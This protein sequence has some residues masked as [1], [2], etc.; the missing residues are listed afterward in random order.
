MMCA[1]FNDNPRITIIFG[2]NPSNTSD[3]TDIITFYYELSSLVWLISKY[4]LLIIGVD[5]NTQI[6]KKP[7]QLRL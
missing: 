1:S 3:E 2:Y 7:S 4:N 5:M 6:Y